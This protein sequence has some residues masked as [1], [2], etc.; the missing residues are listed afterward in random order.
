MRIVGEFTGSYWALK[1][2]P[3]SSQGGSLGSS[4]LSQMVLAMIRRWRLVR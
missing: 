1:G 4:P 2:H 3:A